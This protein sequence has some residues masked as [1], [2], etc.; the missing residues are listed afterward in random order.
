MSIDLADYEKKTRKAVKSFW[1]TRKAASQQQ[2]KVGVSDRGGRSGVAAGKNMD[3]FLAL[4]TDIVR[5]NGLKKADICLE[6]KVLTLPG[7]FRPT[8]LWD[9][10]VMNDGRLVAAIEFK[11]QV[12]PSFGNNTNNRAEEAIG[13]AVDLWTAYREGAFGDK[14]ASICGLAD[15]A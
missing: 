5:K 7:Y 12:G 9:M 15:A 10:L 13:N 8:K 6:R 2:A 3:G 11:S 4:V 14:S 1:A